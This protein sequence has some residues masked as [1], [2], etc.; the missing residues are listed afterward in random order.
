MWLA[1][2]ADCL[3]LLHGGSAGTW[4]V[5]V[6]GTDSKG[7]RMSVPW[8]CTKGPKKGAMWG[9]QGSPHCSCCLRP[10]ARDSYFYCLRGPQEPNR[11]AYSE[12]HPWDPALNKVNGTEVTWTRAL[13]STWSNS[14]CGRLSD[15]FR[16]Q[17][18]LEAQCCFCHRHATA[19]FRLQ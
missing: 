8:K 11:L 15:H 4:C 6:P 3:Q 16:S 14:L 7:T 13:G 1:L 9:A 10:E 5:L 19:V 12:L 17:R 2:A 18:D